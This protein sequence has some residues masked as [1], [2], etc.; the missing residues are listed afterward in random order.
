MN[1]SD[2]VGEPSFLAMDI[3]D[4]Q[5]IDMYGADVNVVD[6][7][8]LYLRRNSIITDDSYYNLMD[9]PTWNSIFY[10]VGRSGYKPTNIGVKTRE[11]Q[12]RLIHR[13]QL[14]LHYEEIT[15]TREIYNFLDLLGDLGGVTEV[16]M[17]IFGFFL[18][19][20]SEHAF[21]LQSAKRFFLAKTEDEQ[22][23]EPPT[24]EQ[25]AKIREKLANP[26]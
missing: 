8:S 23:F 3:F 7:L 1:F 4:T 12:P 6:W 9:E 13:A 10:D 17:L 25:Q 18:F 26:D 19:P 16:L 21:N 5:L 22:L 11:K 24:E 15:Y 20:I 14:W 2:R